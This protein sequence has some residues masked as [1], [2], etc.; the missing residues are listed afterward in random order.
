M[1]RWIPGSIALSAVAALAGATTASAQT[2]G[3]RQDLGANTPSL[4]AHLSER[5]NFRASFPEAARQGPGEF[6]RSYRSSANL[7]GTRAEATA[8][9]D[10]GLDVKGLR[11]TGGALQERE[12]FGRNAAA[13]GQQR[14][15]DTAIGDSERWRPYLGLGWDNS[16]DRANRLGIQLDIGVIFDG[17]GLDQSVSGDG[18]GLLDRQDFLREEFQS[19]RY[20]PSISADVEYRF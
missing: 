17:V 16:M 4:T 19:F 9:M 5:L 14:M 1:K 10:W 12:P 3:A 2:G 18:K 7:W 20:T 11:V 13:L 15:P 8:L 6:E